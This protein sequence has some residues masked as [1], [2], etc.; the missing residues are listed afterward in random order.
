MTPFCVPSHLFASRCMFRRFIVRSVVSSYA[1]SCSR[2]FQHVRAVFAV[3]SRSFYSPES[4][5]PFSKSHRPVISQLFLR[6]TFVLASFVLQSSSYRFFVVL[7]VLRGVL[8]MSC[9]S[10][11]Y[12]KYDQPTYDLQQDLSTYLIYL[13]LDIQ[14]FTSFNFWVLGTPMGNQALRCYGSDPGLLLTGCTGEG[15][16]KCSLGRTSLLPTLD[17]HSAERGDVKCHDLSKW[18]LWYFHLLCSYLFYV[19]GF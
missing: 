8:P 12:L 2:I 4:S 19:S 16:D 7:Q 13:P 11:T 9:L 18:R 6:E 10:S 1:P 15:I 17:M 5:W 3:I 14:E